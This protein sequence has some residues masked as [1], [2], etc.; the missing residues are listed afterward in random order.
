M[1][2]HPAGRDNY[3]NALRSW[4][5]VPPR[6]L[7][8]R[9]ADALQYDGCGLDDLW[10]EIRDWLCL[11]GVV[12]TDQVLGRA[13]I[14]ADRQPAV[15]AFRTISQQGS[16]MNLTRLVYAST[17]AC[18]D[19]STF[20]AILEK[21]RSNNAR[22]LITGALVIGETTFL[23]LLE[24]P[25]D[26]IGRCFARIMQDNRHQDIQAISCGDVAHRL[27]QDWTLHRIETSKIRQEILTRYY[28]KG[29]FN[30]GLM[31]E[32]AIGDLCLTLAEGQWNTETV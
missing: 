7:V 28:V 32:F 26:A 11:N 10:D 13:V 25:R 3:P 16:K 14:E 5:E 20:D 31:S 4:P 2:D 27:F 8:L 15:P 1:D 12:V 29:K 9:L 17:H 18:H 23:Q 30:P 6:D 19:V 24:G 21:S 22:D